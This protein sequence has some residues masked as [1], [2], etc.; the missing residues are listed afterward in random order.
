MVKIDLKRRTQRS[1]STVEFALSLVVLITLVSGLLDLGRVYFVYTQLEDAAGEGA[2]Y[3]C[4]NPRC[5]VSGAGCTDPDNAEYRIKNSGG[6]LVDWSAISFQLDPI[7][8][9]QNCFSAAYYDD[10]TDALITDASYDVRDTIVVTISY[11]F[12]L[13]TPV[14][15]NIAGR[16]TLPLTV[17]ATQSII[18]K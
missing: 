13:L 10:D 7:T 6:G 8:S 18:E 14:I 17:R 3:L 4:F 15:P 12:P 1:Q 11:Q 16:A 9:C 2:L 5:K